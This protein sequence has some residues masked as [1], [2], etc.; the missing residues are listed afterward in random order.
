M[1]EPFFAGSEE[2]AVFSG[3]FAGGEEDGFGEVGRIAG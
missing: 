1:Q 2:A 3:D